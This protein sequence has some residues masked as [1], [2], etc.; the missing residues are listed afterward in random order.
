MGTSGDAP[1]PA[2]TSTLAGSHQ[3]SYQHKQKSRGRDT[4]P[5]APSRP[6]G[7]DAR[8]GRVYLPGREEALRPAPARASRSIAAPFPRH[9]Q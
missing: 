9:A 3:L 4:T 2:L 5:T 6:G 1:P 7:S 8:A